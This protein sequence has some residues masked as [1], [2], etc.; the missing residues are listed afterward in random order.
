MVTKHGKLAQL[1]PAFAHLPEWQLELAE[2]DNKVFDTDTF[3]TFTGEIPRTLSPKQTVIAKAQA[4]AEMTGCDFAI[5]SEGTIG[6]HPAFPFVTA[7]HELLAFVCL[8]RNLEIVESYVSPNIVAHAT[9]IDRET[10]L[11][12]LAA[13]LDLPSHAANLTIRTGDKIEFV[14]GIR[15]AVELKRLVE[16]HL[17]NGDVRLSVESDY[18]AMN[19]PSRQANIAECATRL[20]ERVSNH[21]PACDEIGWG[22]VGYEYGVPCRACEMPTTTVAQAERFGCVGCDHVELRSLG[23]EA[24][25]PSRCDFCNP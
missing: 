25:D 2:V 14:K 7:D 16:L 5:A 18:R 22:K 19:S 20:A 1:E 9:D 24:A 3:G 21:C 23:V 17:Q 13:K 12:A 8:S 10:D 6:P 15:E 11:A 4:G